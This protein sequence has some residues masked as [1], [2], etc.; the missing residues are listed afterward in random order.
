MGTTSSPTSAVFMKLEG[1]GKS[2][3][4]TH[5]IL[6][7]KVAFVTSKFFLCVVVLFL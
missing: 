4:Q 5:K 7:S 2:S 3:T 6:D 1:S